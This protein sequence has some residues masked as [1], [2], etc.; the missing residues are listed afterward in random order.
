[1]TETPTA[2]LAMPRHFFRQPHA[3]AE[4]VQLAARLIAE[5]GL[6]YGL[7]KRKAARQLGLP[8]NFPLPANA[9]VEAAVRDYQALY[10]EEE[11]AERLRWLRTQAVTLMRLLS[12]FSPWLTGAV[13]EGT[14]GRFGRIEIL[15]YPDSA[16]DVE[17]FLLDR[18]IPF[19]HG[20]PRQESQE[21]V[22][23]LDDE[24]FPADLLIE[25][26]NRER[27]AARYADGRP[28]ARA[29]L[30]AVEAL[31]AAEGEVDNP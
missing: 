4:L 3:R 10:Q 7:A 11:H 2:P 14:A 20:R 21:A 5:E 29:R 23:V 25:A 18:R 1:M 13:L 28:R 24:D 16:K 6:E 19:H 22:Y 12:P 9:E 15:L 26:P 31:L 30:A 27:M 8:A 17:I